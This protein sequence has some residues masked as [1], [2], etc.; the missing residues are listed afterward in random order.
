MARASARQRGRK[1][2]ELRNRRR[3]ALCVAC[4]AKGR[5]TLATE[6]D[7]IVPLHKGG[8]DTDENTQPLCGECHAA[9]TAHDMGYR[10]RVTIGLD[11]WPVE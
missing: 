9:K 7:H 10:P 6:V 11:G 1:G 4:E 2:C 3:K 8:P 5:V